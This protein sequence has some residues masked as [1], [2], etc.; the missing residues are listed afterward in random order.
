MKIIRLAPAQRKLPFQVNLPFQL[1]LPAQEFFRLAASCLMALQ[2]SF[3]P[4]LSAAPAEKSA[5]TK[6]AP[7]KPAD[8]IL[9]V[10]QSELSRATSSLSKT[11]PAPYFLS[12]TV[13]DQ[14]IVVLVGAYVSLLTDAAVQRRQA[15]V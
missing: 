14:D 12:Y 2:L 11:D 15:D 13:N 9:K 1:K 5:S 3:S 10:M 7:A 6:T 8:P 4:I